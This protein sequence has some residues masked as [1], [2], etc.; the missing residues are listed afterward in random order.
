M[1]IS[2][3]QPDI[4]EREIELVNEVLRSPQLSGGP[5]LE[6][7]ERDIAHYVG[8]PFAV[9]VTNGTCGLH[10]A[11]AALGIGEGDEVITTPFSFVASAN[12]ILFERARPV[13][14]DIE[15]G[16]LSMDPDL[17]ERAITPRTKAILPVHV[18][19][20]PAP[21]DRITT[22]AAQHGLPVIEDACEALGAEYNGR[23]AG[24]FG[25]CATFAFYPNKQMTTAEGGVIVTAREDLA[26]AFRS[27]RNQGRDRAGTWLQHVRLGYNYR[28]DEIRAALGVAQLE[29]LEELLGKRNR[30]ASAYSERLRGQDGIE[31]QGQSPHVR[32]SWFVYVIRVPKTVDRDRVGA[33]LAERGIPTRPYFHPI[34]LQPFYREA[35]GYRDG[36][37]PICEQ[38]ARRGLALPFH[39]S[40]SDETV[41]RVCDEL[42]AAVRRESSHG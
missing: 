35:F 12:C 30:V 7:F 14:V 27:M 36:D 38:I 33:R 11:V 15:P 4:G 41:D 2:L 10:L 9:G 6:R 1:D 21:M 16:S 25:D 24:T 13:F 17:I 26:E 19:G 42:R 31:V 3:S 22:I 40:L 23:K 18:F 34:H 28:L 5:F 8:V 37:F 29:R 39:G 32:M 20:H